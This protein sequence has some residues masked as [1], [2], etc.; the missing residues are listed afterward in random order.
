[1]TAPPQRPWADVMSCV[2]LGLSSSSCLECTV[3]D[4]GQ[5]QADSNVF[6]ELSGSLGGACG[7]LPG[8]RRSPGCSP[9]DTNESS[10]L[11][12][13]FLWVFLEAASCWV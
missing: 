7:R 9:R 11:A 3:R 12:G 6:R 5:D 1:M 2:I 8:S 13:M 4:S 10:P